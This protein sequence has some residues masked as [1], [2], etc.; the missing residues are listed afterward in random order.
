MVDNLEKGDYFHVHNTMGT[1][2]K[3]HPGYVLLLVSVKEELTSFVF[4]SMEQDIQ[5]MNRMVM[6]EASCSLPAFQERTPG[7]QEQVI[8]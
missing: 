8:R 4:N 6:R 5:C 7:A 1:R 2:R 3:I